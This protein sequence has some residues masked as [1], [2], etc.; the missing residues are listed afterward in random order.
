MKLHKWSYWYGE[1]PTL[2]HPDQLGD[3]EGWVGEP[4]FNGS[5]LFLH[6]MTD[7]SWQFWNRHRQVMDYEPSPA[8]QKSLDR[9]RL[10]GWW[11][12]DGE[13]RHNK[14]VNIRH[15]IVLWDTWIMDGTLL[16][17][18]PYQSRRKILYDLKLSVDDGGI[19]YTSTSFAELAMPIWLTGNFREYFDRYLDNPEIEGLVLKRAGGILNLGRTKAAES[20][21]MV[22]ARKPSGRYRF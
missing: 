15:R 20:T 9:L 17:R 1:R 13:L 11:V 10:T 14:T 18:S 4:K 7:G 2:I 6:H 21:W 22:K 12:F 3:Y 8:V 16:A 19:G 5:R